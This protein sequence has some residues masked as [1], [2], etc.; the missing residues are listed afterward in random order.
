MSTQLGKEITGF[1]YGHSFVLSGGAGYS[2]M[3]KG[4]WLTKCKTTHI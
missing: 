3:G 1:Y 4:Q 2:W